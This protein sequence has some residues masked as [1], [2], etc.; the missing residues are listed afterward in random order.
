MGAV[1][2]VPDNDGHL[3]V[4]CRP[5]FLSRNVGTCFASSLDEGALRP[6]APSQGMDMS[7]FGR[8]NTH[9]AVYRRSEKQTCSVLG[10]DVGEG[11][12]DTEDDRLGYRSML[13]PTGQAERV[14]PFLHGGLL[15]PAS[16]NAT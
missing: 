13:R 14:V 8:K 5:T 10:L 7:G 16:L 3:Q 12:G 6:P 9:A 1:F 15:S 2:P 4:P 11:F